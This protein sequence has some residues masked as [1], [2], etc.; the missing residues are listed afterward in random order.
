M[1]QDEPISMC[2]ILQVLGEKTDRSKTALETSPL[3]GPPDHGEC[4][5]PEHM[6]R[7]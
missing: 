4:A 3:R 1:A 2:H 7:P 5:A 6:P